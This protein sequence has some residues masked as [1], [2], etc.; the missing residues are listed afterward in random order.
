MS[1]KIRLK[2]LIGKLN[3]KITDFAKKTG[4]PYRTLQN[5]LS[6]ERQPSAENLQK[7]AICFNI[8]L[9]WL[10]TGEGNMFKSGESDMS[11]DKISSSDKTESSGMP[12]DFIDKLRDDLRNKDDSFFAS[13][14]M[15]KDRIFDVLLGKTKLR[16]IEVIELA[17]KLNRSLDEY[18]YLAGYIPGVFNRVLQNPKMID[19]L[20]NAGKLSDKEIDQAV[21]AFAEVFERFEKDQAAK[22]KRTS[23]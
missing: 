20:R 9:N 4:I 13:L 23:K 1:I 3:L 17:R 12:L 19:A 15:S 21:D 10:L 16:R 5:Y 18:V 11:D 22:T 7:I 14:S 6:G 2:F 8:D